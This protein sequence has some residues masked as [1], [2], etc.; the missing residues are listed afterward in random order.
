MKKIAKQKPQEEKSIDIL[1]RLAK[2]I[3]EA[4]VDIHS[5]KF[6]VKAMKL[7]MMSIESDTSI[8]KVDIER[9]KNEIGEVKV[10]IGGLKTDIATTK[11]GIKEIKRDTEGII[12]TTTHILKEAVTHDEHSAL[13]QR[14]TALEQS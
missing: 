6:Y 1:K 12:E 4:T 5:I 11:K 13:S 9:L 2:R 3:E 7:D 10:D 14:V 8:M